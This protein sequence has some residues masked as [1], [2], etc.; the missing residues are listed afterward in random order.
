MKRRNIWRRMT[1][2]QKIRGG[3]REYDSCVACHFRDKLGNSAGQDDD[4]DD[5][6]EETTPHGGD[7][8]VAERCC[9]AVLLKNKDRR[10]RVEKT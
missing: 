7:G 1:V 2:P 9:V 4:D 10:G 8:T 5:N 6:K 3:G